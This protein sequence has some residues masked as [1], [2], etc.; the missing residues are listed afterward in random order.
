MDQK[1]ANLI[2]VLQQ[3]CRH[4]QNQNNNPP[5]NTPHLPE[6]SQK[7]GHPELRTAKTFFKLILRRPVGGGWKCLVDPFKIEKTRLLTILES[8]AYI[9]ST[10]LAISWF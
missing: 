7:E 4:L 6:G 8:N 9:E 10:V 2:N 5:T 1:Q 3:V